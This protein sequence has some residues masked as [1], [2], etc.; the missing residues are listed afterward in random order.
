MK[1]TLIVKLKC[2]SIYV[3]ENMDISTAIPILDGFKT[4][5]LGNYD[6]E[7]ADSKTGEKVNASMS[8]IR[9]IEFMF[10]V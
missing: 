10:Q 8:D 3:T 5:L 9:S 1:Y 7:I 2:G 6:I 4:G